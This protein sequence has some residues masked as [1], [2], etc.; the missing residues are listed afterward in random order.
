MLHLLIK[1]NFFFLE[2]RFR[3]KQ[4]ITEILVN[5]PAFAGSHNI[6][7]A[8][9]FMHAKSQRA[10]FHLIA[11]RKFHLIA[12]A[13]RQRASLDSFKFILFADTVKQLFHLLFFYFQLC[14]IGNRLI[15]TASAYPKMRTYCLRCLDFGPLQDLHQASLALAFSLFVHKKLD[16]LPR[17]SIFH[18]DLLILYMKNSFIRKFNLFNNSFINL[19]FFH[20]NINSFYQFSYTFL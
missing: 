6:I 11:K 18:N 7:K 3:T 16:F 5:D 19:T 4:D 8:A 1:A 17:K 10:V 14:F 12:V 2:I 15:E 20:I 9:P 13:V